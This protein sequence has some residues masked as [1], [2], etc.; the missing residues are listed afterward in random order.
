MAPFKRLTV[1]ED[2]LHEHYDK[3]TVTIHQVFLE[4]IRE[5]LTVHLVTAANCQGR[6]HYNDQGQHSE[7]PLITTAVQLMEPQIPSPRG[8]SPREQSLMANNTNTLTAAPVSRILFYALGFSCYT[9]VLY[10][11]FAFT[12]NLP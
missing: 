11:L 8:S 12:L 6:C 3:A 1:E 9:L 4:R 10:T 5:F 2:P 7:K